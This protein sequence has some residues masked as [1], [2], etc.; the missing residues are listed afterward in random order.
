LAYLA[1]TNYY[2][3]SGAIV[4]T[5]SMDMNK[6]TPMTMNSSVWPSTGSTS[7]TPYYD[8]N[9]RLSPGPGFAGNYT[10]QKIYTP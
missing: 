10:V 9:I 8:I 6:L 1:A 5:G 4:R 7:T 2:I 3:S